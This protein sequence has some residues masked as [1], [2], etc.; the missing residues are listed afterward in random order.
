MKI[1]LPEEKN[2]PFHIMIKPHGPLCNLRCTYCFYLHKRDMFESASKWKMPEE[3][4]ETFIIQYIKAQ[5][6]GHPVNFAWQ[7]GEPTLM[8]IE[9]FKKAVALQKKYKKDGQDIT[10]SFQTNAMLI[11]DE[12]AGFFREHEFL[13]GVSIDGPK[14]VHN[15]YR[16]DKN[17][18]GSFDRVMHGV[19]RLKKHQVE[20]NALCCVNNL[21]PANTLEIYRFL[22]TYFYYIQFIPVVEEKE[23]FKE[24]PF[25][26][27]S[28]KWKLRGKQ[29]S[30]DIVHPWCVSPEGY[31]KF[32]CT[33]FDEWVRNDVG[34]IF[35]QIFDVT[36]SRWVGSP[37]ALC[38]FA[39]TCGK[40]LVLEHNG[41]LYACDH[42]VYPEYLVGNIMNEPLEKFV[43]SKQQKKFG[44]DKFTRLPKK[45]KMCRF[46]MLC[47]G[48]CP[49][50]RFITTSDRET[51]HNYLCKGY[52][53][54]FEHTA[55]Y[56]EI[57]GE[58][59]QQRR[60][61]SFVMD[62]VKQED[63]ANAKPN[64]LCPCRSGKKFK[65]CC[66]KK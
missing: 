19:E 40:A 51:E 22:R 61:P 11:D 36:L 25:L 10:N 54:F 21:S 26:A 16:M 58:L 50:N 35:V 4:L 52:Y 13:I 1:P 45:C 8:G 66:M 31:G 59:V 55:P 15:Y 18:Q 49:K 41:D 56:M 60:P 63:L 12:W 57:M 47:Q 34:R 30:P 23:F 43:R 37:P 17:G 7:G 2:F 46:L 32:L 20:F 38:I 29:K 42:F 6:E 64:D 5:P 62:Q 27:D 48:G 14:S 53:K 24:A 65:K 33:V 9:F 28:D 39:P 3:V 44:Q